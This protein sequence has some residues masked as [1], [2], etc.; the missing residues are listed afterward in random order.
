MNEQLQ[1]ELT[2]I[3]TNINSGA[4]T[5]WG[6]LSEQTPDV[7]QQLL[8]WHVVYSAILCVF[9]A[10]ALI[11]I[12]STI[13]FVITNIE[14]LKVDDACLARAAAQV[15]ISVLSFIVCADCINITWL[16]LLIAP[17]VWL[18]EYITAMV[19]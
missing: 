4:E 8:L 3:I 10:I 5:A 6:F 13:M 9:G 11:F 19:K 12:F 17:K 15:F 18:L 2:K 16:Q 1:L 14:K 7:V